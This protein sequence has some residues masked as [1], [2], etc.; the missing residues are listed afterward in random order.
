MPHNL[1]HDKSTLVQVMAW[2]HQ[3]PS[4]YLSQCWPRCMLPYGIT[5]PQWG[6]K[7]FPHPWLQQWQEVGDHNGRRCRRPTGSPCSCDDSALPGL[8]THAGADAAG[9]K[10][11]MYKYIVKHIHFSWKHWQRHYHMPP[12]ANFESEL[13]SGWNIFSFQIF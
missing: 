6:N 7:W 9:N 11:I 4:H 1:N 13:W 3:A 8:G 5:R 10:N 12:V 2:C